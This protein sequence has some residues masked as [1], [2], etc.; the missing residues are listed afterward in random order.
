MALEGAKYN[1]H[2]NAIAPSLST[3]ANGADTGPGLSPNYISPLVLA[4]CSDDCPDPTGGLYEVGAGWCAKLRWQQ[5]GGVC[6]PVNLELTPETVLKHWSDIASFNSGREEYP[7][8]SSDSTG[9]IMANL[10]NTAVGNMN[11]QK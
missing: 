1:I 6:F 3:T 7:E 9:K 4:L 5:A 10:E 11:H 8:R 2:V